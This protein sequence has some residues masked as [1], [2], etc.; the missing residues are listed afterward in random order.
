MFCEERLGITSYTFI[1]HIKM[2]DR[3][4]NGSV[5]KNN[6]AS[7]PAKE[8]KFMLVLSI[9]NEL[10]RVPNYKKTDKKSMTNG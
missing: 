7:K 3:F 4:R 9:I 6:I 8:A 1:S 2:S 10:V 5:H